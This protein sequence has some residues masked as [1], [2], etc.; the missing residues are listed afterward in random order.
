MP[1]VHTDG[2]VGAVGTGCKGATVC[3]DFEECATPKG[4]TVAKAGGNQGLGTRPSTTTTST[5]RRSCARP[6]NPA[7]AGSAVKGVWRRA[8]WCSRWV[9]EVGVIPKTSSLDDARSRT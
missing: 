3:S 6:R 8:F 9:G 2:A 7:V 1:L 4:W 5:A